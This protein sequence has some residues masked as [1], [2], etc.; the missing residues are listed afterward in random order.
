M[1]R[2]TLLLHVVGTSSVIL[3]LVFM[4]YV[5]LMIMFQ[6]YF[7]AIE[8]NKPILLYEIGT[9]FIAIIYGIYLTSLTFRRIVN[10]Y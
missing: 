7:L 8:Y 2:L 6:G 9:A 4:P 1:D 5:F 10:E 3:S